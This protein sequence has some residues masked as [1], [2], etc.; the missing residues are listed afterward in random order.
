M[1]ITHR[2]LVPFSIGKHYKD[3]IW[4][5]IVPMDGCHILLGRPWLFDRSVIYDGRMNTY[6]F[7]KDHKKITLTLLKISPSKT[8]ENPY[9]DV[10]LTTLLKSQQHEIESFK[11][12][13]LLQD[14][15]KS[16]MYMWGG[17]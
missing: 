1:Q 8:K 12:L 16:L 11:D 17:K 3:E 7:Q 13:I 9:L 15:P 5:D 10:F 14:E 6:T 4:Y 2:C